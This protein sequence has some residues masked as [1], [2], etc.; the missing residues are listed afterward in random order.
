MELVNKI[1]RKIYVPHDDTI[2]FNSKH[3]QLGPRFLISHH[4][5][6]Y[7]SRK[8]TLYF[9]VERNRF[10]RVRIFNVFSIDE[11]NCDFVVGKGNLYEHGV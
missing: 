5:S 8:L 1:A 11:M 9:S 3:Y 7:F 6:L 2:F 10:G 4:L